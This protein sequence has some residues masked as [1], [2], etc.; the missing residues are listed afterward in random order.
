[1]TKS[2]DEIKFIL[3]RHREELRE[4]YKITQI[5]IFGSYARGDQKKRSDVDIL[6][7]IEEPVGLLRFVHIENLLSDLLQ[8][9]VDLIPKEGIR[10]ELREKI[11][12]EVVYL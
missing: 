11:I 7:E 10:P 3:I 12:N 6:V 4:K 5:G 1:M 9:K 8:V 2:L